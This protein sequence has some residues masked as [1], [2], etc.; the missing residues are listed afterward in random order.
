MVLTKPSNKNSII[1][2]EKTVK[3]NLSPR[4]EDTKKDVKRERKSIVLLFGVSVTKSDYY[5]L[6]IICISV[7]CI[8]YQL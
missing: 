2:F 8:H 6:I 7:L 4:Q 5:T 3:W 1:I